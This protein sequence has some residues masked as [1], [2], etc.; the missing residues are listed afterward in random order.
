MA[1]AMAR[2]WRL[3]WLGVALATAIGACAP[4]GGDE[5]P[6]PAE[7]LAGALRDSAPAPGSPG[8]WH[9]EVL[10]ARFKTVTEQRLGAEGLVEQEQR[11][12]L[13]AERRTVWFE[14]PCGRPGI[15]FVATLQ[16][17]LKAR[18]LYDAPVTGTLDEATRAAVRRYQAPRGIDSATLSLAAARALGLVAVPPE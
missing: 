6:P 18:G 7:A 14:V 5:A 10:P 9:Q 2:A 12:I 11:Q 4:T 8:C 1:A 3:A 16:R 15:A 17:A 13:L